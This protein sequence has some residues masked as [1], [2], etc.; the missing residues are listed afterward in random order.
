MEYLYHYDELEERQVKIEEAESAGLR[1]VSDSFDDPDWKRGD[2][3]VGTMKFTDEMLPLPDTEPSKSTHVSQLASIDPSKVRPAQVKRIWEERDYL[4]D[5]FVTETI[6][7][8]Y[9]AGNIH[10]GDYVLVHFDDMGEQLVT[11]KIYKS[12]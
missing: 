10:V 7:D 4:Y 1:M 8:M 12:W 11:E 3:I 5:C 2:P 6:K 9:L